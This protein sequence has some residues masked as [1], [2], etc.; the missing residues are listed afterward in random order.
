MAQFQ[1]Q[2]EEYLIVIVQQKREADE[3]QKSVAAYSER[4][5]AEEIKCK[6]MADN[7]QR[8]LD[9]AVPALEEAQKVTWCPKTS[10]PKHLESIN[11]HNSLHIT[12]IG[13]RC[14]GHKS[15]YKYRA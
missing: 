5:S 15:T 11:H 4:I 6:Q 8:D 10:Y 9:E 2:C 12:I 7:A 1:K 13:K 14:R 3:Q